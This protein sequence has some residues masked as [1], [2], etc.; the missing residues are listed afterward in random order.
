MAVYRVRKHAKAF[1]DEKNQKK[2]NKTKNTELNPGPNL[3]KSRCQYLVSLS[4]VV[5]RKKDQKH[6]MRRVIF[7]S[8][9][10]VAKR[11]SAA[12]CYGSEIKTDMCAYCKLRD[13]LGLG[14]ARPAWMERNCLFRIIWGSHPLVAY[15][16][17]N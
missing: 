11:E 15:V 2:D 6:T 10:S 3:I 7:G 8:L 17:T 16:I 1:I 9:P 5:C 12:Y 4:R 14:D 13:F